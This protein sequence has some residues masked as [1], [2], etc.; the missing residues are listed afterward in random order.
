MTSDAGV[1][2]RRVQAGGVALG[3]R[4]WGQGDV[5]VVFIHGNLASK[6]WLELAAPLFP[7]GIRT[8]GIDWRGCGD[9][10]RPAA[11]PG[12]ANYSMQQHA[13][14]MIAALDALG[15]DFCHLATHSTGGIIAARMLL[16]QPER[17]GRVLHL[18]PISPAGAAFGPEQVQL[19]RDMSP[20]KPMTRA[21]MA[22]AASSLFEPQ[23]LSDPAGPRFKAEV[24][25]ARRAAFERIIDQTFTVA[26]GIWLG[27]PHNLTWE[28]TD[29]RLAARMG[30]MRHPQLVLWGED[31]LWIVRADLERMTREMPDCRLV[32]LPKLGHSAN[33]ELPALFAGYFGAWF[34]GLPR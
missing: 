24:D 2:P 33:L 16:M 31:D 28:H 20:S 7:P 10:D 9:S 21:I 13:E 6:E 32:V 17:F 4:E 29:G 25:G 15:I 19:F 5:T 18:D 34:G 3:W 26:E 27:T 23:S 8:V 11:T 22:T 1:A 12:Y 30:E 14:D